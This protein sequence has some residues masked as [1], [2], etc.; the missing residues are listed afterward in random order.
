[1]VS[2]LGQKDQEEELGS[3][4]CSSDHGLY[5]CGVLSMFVGGGGGRGDA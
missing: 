2:D 4:M 3:F 5:L 1:M